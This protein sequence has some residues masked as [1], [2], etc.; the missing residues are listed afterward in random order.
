[1]R[2]GISSTC[3]IGV[4]IALSFASVSV[5]NAQTPDSTH[6]TTTRKVKKTVKRTTSSTQQIP[7]RKENGGEV[8]QPAPTV[9]QD[10]IAAAER[11]RQDS[12]AAANERARQDSIARVEQMRRDSIA[13]A[14]RRRRDSI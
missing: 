10:S 8:A 4:A 12:I 11:A 5:A 6:K 3:V 7:I 1:M 13:F 2:I 9:N 14:E